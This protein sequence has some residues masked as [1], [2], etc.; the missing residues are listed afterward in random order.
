VS[1]GVRLGLF[2]GGSALFAYLVARIGLGTL[3]ADAARTGWMFLPILLLYGL[4]YVCNA[5]A[6]W[7]MMADEPARPP[8][9]RAYAITVSGFS[10]NFV[11]PMINVGG[12]P[13]KVAAV[14]QWLGVRRAAGSVVCYQMLH[15]LAMVLSWFTALG[16]GAVLLPHD[17]AVLAALAVAAAVLV[18]LGALLVSGHRS[19]VLERL[20]DVLHRVPLLG[21]LARLV[22]PRRAV[23]AQVDAQIAE[24]YRGNRRRFY[25]ALALEYLS[26]AIYMAEY[27]LIFLSVGLDAGYLKAYLIGG[28]STLM[29]NVLFIIPFEIGAKEGSLYLLF[30]LLGLDPALGVYTAIVS[31]L[32]DLVWIACGLTLVWFSGRRAAPQRA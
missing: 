21:R 22:E 26:R 24:F 2:V 14:S 32:R 29:L 11:T 3:A 4:V 9:W 27:W 15:T 13:F 25:Q 1:R 7:L 20:L 5:W 28:L 17:P 23:L 31:R 30:R 6:W 19:G 10:L 16:L 8:F 18:G 12:E